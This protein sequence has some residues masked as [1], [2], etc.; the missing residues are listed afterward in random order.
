MKELDVVALTID[1]PDLGLKAGQVGTIV[2]EFA[3]EL[4]Y[5]EF[6]GTDG[7]TYALTDLPAEQLMVLRFEGKGIGKAAA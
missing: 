3:P 1:R 7:Y 5:V 4:M 2:D 6:V